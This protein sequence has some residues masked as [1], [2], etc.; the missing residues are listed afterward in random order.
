MTLPRGASLTARGESA[1]KAREKRLGAGRGLGK[2]PPHNRP[3]QGISM[4]ADKATHTATE[5]DYPAHNR[6]YLGFIKMLKWSIVIVAIVA[7]I[8]I[9]TIA[10]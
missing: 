5:M 10:N 7:A 6:N 2:T 1:V 3:T 8:V 9:Y 4:A